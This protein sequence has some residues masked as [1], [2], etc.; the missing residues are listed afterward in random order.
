MKDWFEA[1]WFDGTVQIPLSI[2][3]EWNTLW[4]ADLTMMNEEKGTQTTGGYC[5]VDNNA[6]TSIIFSGNWEQQHGD[7]Y[8][9]TD[10][11]C[12][13]NEIVFLTEGGGEYVGYW[14]RQKFCIG[15]WT[16][17]GENDPHVQVCNHD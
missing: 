4:I 3:E 16:P 9:I 15:G 7:W 6:S 17:T 13:S 2:K 14:C 8:D 12:S 11:V 10:A 5:A 1:A